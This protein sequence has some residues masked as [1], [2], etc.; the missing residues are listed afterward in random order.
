M[1]KLDGFP[2]A[3]RMAG[4]ALPAEL[5]HVCIHMAGGALFGCPL[6][7]I[8]LMAGCTCHTD[9]LPGEGEAGLAVV[10]TH[11]PPI[12]G[13]VT[14]S[15]IRAQLSLMAIVLSMTGNTICECALKR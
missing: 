2:C 4:F 12:C 7:Y 6:E 3:G 14:G 10:E 11:L 15:A 1:I 5:S 13:S 9:V 8:I